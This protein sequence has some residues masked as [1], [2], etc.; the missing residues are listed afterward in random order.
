VSVTEVSLGLTGPLTLGLAGEIGAACDRAAD[1]DVL[2]LRLTGGA[3]T[4]PGWPGTVDVAVVSKWEKALR[5]L[6]RLAAFTVGVCAGPADQAVLEVLLATDHRIADV[7]MTVVTGGSAEGL[8]PGV[9]L[10]RLVQ[11]AGLGW[12]RRLALLPGEFTASDLQ[13]AGLLD[14]V[15][16]DADAAIEAVVKRASGLAGSEVAMRRMLLVDAVT[17]AHEEA[18]GAHL[19]ACDRTLRR[20]RSDA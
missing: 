3:I 19:A 18:L 14:E 10:H 12:A 11:Q 17:V 1:A 15:T 13:A 9:V 2:V 7:G 20:S 8:W 16:A 4:R 5:R 6:E